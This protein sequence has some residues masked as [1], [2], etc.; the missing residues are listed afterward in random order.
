MNVLKDWKSYWERRKESFIEECASANAQFLLDLSQPEITQE[1][2]L[3]DIIDI[4]KDSLF[5]KEQGYSVVTD[6][7]SFRA[8]LP[9]MRYEDFAPLINQET[10]T[11]GGV[12]TCSPVMRWLK[13]S[14][15]TGLPKKIPYTMHWILNYRIPAMK[16]MWG[17]YLRYYPELIAHPYA[18]LDTQTV[19]ENT[20]DFLQGVPYQAISN[21]HPRMNTLDWNPPWYEAPWFHDAVPTSYDDRMYHRIRHLAGKDLHFISSIN[22]ST[23]L[24]LRDHIGANKEKLIQDVLHGTVNGKPYEQPNPD[25]A[26]RLT[27]VLSTP[28]FTL[29]DI[30]PTLGL[31]SC[32]F[33]A[34]AGLYQ[35]A[36]DTTF[37]GVD[38]LPFM[39]CGTEGVVTIPIDDNPYSQPLAINQAFFEFVD[40]DIPLNEKLENGEKVHTLRCH[41]VI[42]GKNYHLIMS[43]A[44]GLF[45]FWTGDIYHVD[46]MENGVP[47]I[48]FL[49]RDGVFHSFTGEKLSELHVTQALMKGLTVAEKKRGLYLC[50]PKWGQ[51]PSYVIV[52]EADDANPTLNTMLSKYVDEAL[53]DINIEYESKRSSKRLGSVEVYTVP[54]NTILSYVERQRQTGNTNQYKYKPFRKDIDFLSDFLIT[55]LVEGASNAGS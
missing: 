21:R 29:K 9:I 47:W 26:I 50:G 18:T 11:K 4:S 36:L 42:P 40:E 5:W 39:S 20:Q 3:K 38:K 27:G 6:E 43:Q 33:S 17:T 24:A 34:S 55:K 2:V 22:P 25:E 14:G 16:A 32:W 46:R 19:R 30:W 35:N 51:P 48:H 31:Y 10:R 28:N 7:D 1:K 52:A 54:E 23:L 53:M 15:T 45:R 41:E 37:A 13:T 8:I 44:N 12:L 49:H